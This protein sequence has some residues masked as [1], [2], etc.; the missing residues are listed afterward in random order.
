MER[1]ISIREK[2]YYE[3]DYQMRMLRINSTEYLLRVMGRGID[4]SSCYEYEV[5][6]KVSM[7][8][9]FERGN[10]RGRD[11]ELLM[12]SIREAIRETERHLLNIH[13]L[14]LQP[15][16]IFYEEKKFYFCYFPPSKE[17]IWRVSTG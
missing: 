3:E 1:R 2:G 11:V 16:Y 17:N 4:D 10:M 14:L 7:S 15:E 5:S 6:G 8:A 13:C 9:M 12:D